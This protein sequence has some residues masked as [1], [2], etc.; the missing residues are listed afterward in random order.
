MKIKPFVSA[1]FGALMLTKDYNSLIGREFC[2]RLLPLQR[3]I[4]VSGAFVWR[5]YACSHAHTSSAL[6]LLRTSKC[7][8]A[9]C[10]QPARRGLILGHARPLTINSAFFSARSFASVPSLTGMKIEPF[11][12]ATAP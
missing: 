2:N 1:V 8:S 4:I 6:K 11:V 5:M 12:S 10:L 7:F 3:A 9:T